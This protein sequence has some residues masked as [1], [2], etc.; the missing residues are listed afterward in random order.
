MSYKAYQVILYGKFEKKSGQQI[1]DKMSEW[2][3][4]S[5]YFA[6]ASVNCPEI[7]RVSH[8]AAVELKKTTQLRPGA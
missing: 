5:T 6:A 2:K 8:Y 1:N 7:R 3:L 4:K